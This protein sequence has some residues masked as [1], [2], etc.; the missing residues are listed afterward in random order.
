VRPLTEK[1]PQRAADLI[2]GRCR[3]GTVE[4]RIVDAGFRIVARE[5]TAA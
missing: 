1:S 3:G 5:S 4:E 2:V